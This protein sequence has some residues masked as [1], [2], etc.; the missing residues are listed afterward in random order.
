MKAQR[1]IITGEIGAGKTTFCSHITNWARRDG[2][3]VRGV[4]SPGVFED[5]QK[6]G[7]SAVNLKNNESRPLAYLRNEETSGPKT[8]RWAFSEET[9]QWGNQFLARATPCDML[10]VDELGPIELERGG[11]WT[12]GLQIIDG[13]D[14]QAAIVVIRP[15]L[16]DQASARWPASSTVVLK[17]NVYLPGLAKKVYRRLSFS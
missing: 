13:G 16:L 2:L 5:G 8:K 6:V 12:R 4:I 10:V 11:G 9:I 14:F 1:V 17:P 15:H 3:R 7:I